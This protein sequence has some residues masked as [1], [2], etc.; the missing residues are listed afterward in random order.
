MQCI[1]CLAFE[2]SQSIALEQILNVFGHFPNSET[3]YQFNYLSAVQF[4]RNIDAGQK[5]E[6]NRYAFL[7]QDVITISF[8]IDVSQ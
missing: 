5:E 3:T 7:K 8:E 6:N 2:F 1:L 4:E